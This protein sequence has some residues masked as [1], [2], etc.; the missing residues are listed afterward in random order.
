MEQKPTQ[1]DFSLTKIRLTK[2]GGAAITYQ[3]N[4]NKVHTECTD[5]IHADLRQLFTRLRPLMAQVFQLSELQNEFVVVN[6]IGIAGKEE[7][8]GCVMVGD[9]FTI[10]GQ[11]TKICTPRIKFLEQYYGF[12]NELAD[13][14]ANIESEVYEYLFN[15]K[16]EELEEL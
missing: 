15:G 3:V 5:Y 12:E 1:G 13:I 10:S 9:Y 7:N 6:G 2:D 11:P 8:K 14:A 4:S 16:H